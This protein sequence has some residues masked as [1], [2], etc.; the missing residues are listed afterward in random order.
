MEWV[1]W[2]ILDGREGR[3]EFGAGGRMGAG[4]SV[5]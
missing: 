1:G 5:G 3:D 2:F 4:T